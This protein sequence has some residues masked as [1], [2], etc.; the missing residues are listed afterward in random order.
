[1]SLLSALHP[2][3]AFSICFF[4]VI[5]A[6][7][8]LSVHAE[9]LALKKG[10]TRGAVGFVLLGFATSLP[11][12]ITTLSSVLLLDNPEMGAGNILGSNCANMFILFLS[13][14]TAKTLRTGERV[15]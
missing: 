7:W 5:I 8:R 10:F 14:L 15:D 13:L 11:E 9:E 12:L 1:M 6:G 3:G 2:W 4:A